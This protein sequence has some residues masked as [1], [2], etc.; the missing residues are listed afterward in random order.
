MGLGFGIV[1]THAVITAITTG[2]V[3]DEDNLRARSSGF[4]V[5]GSGF[6]AQGSGFRVQ[7]SG[8]RAQGSG[9]RAQGSGLR[10]EGG[11]TGEALDAAARDCR[12]LTART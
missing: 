10:A 5:Q 8:F 7:G 9:F 1:V 2:I 3:P 11:K 12:V 4:R 6:R